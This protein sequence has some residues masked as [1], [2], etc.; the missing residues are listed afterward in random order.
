[1]LR[2]CLARRVKKWNDKKYG[3]DGKVESYKTYLFGWE[4]KKKIRGWKSEIRI[5]L[6]L[7]SY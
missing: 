2:V 3:G 1:M 7:Y 6:Q 5:N 4:K